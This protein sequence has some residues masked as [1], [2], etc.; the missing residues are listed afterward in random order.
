VLGVFMLLRREALMA[1]ALPQ[2]VAIGAA[3]ALRWEL[4]GVW[5]LVPALAAAL[6]ALVYLVLGRRS[7]GIG[8]GVLPCLYVAGLCL[9]FLLIANKGQ[10]VSKLQT[11]FTGFDVAVTPERA[12]VAGPILLVIAIVGAVL[13]RR[14]LLLAQAPAAAELAGLGL[15]R[16]DGLFL[17]LLTV[18]TLLGA[19]SVGTV[20]VLVMLFL[21]AAAALPWARRIPAALIVA[22]VLSFVFLGVG[23]YLSNTMNWPLSQSI[24]GVGF[25]AVVGSHV[26]ARGLKR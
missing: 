3:M 1:L 22:A 19:D 5:T 2:V 7:G 26:A 16:W 15:R 11:F 24:G 13:W 4:E 20:M 6:V 18:M 14:W 9:S 25:A 10:E 12:V 21:P 8:T 23:F 17:L